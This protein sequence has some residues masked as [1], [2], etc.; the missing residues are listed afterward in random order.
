MEPSDAGSEQVRGWG[1]GPLCGRLVS[2]LFPL[3][4]SLRV[5]HHNVSS[6]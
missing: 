4:M 6:S 1:G 2:S 5:T 3:Q